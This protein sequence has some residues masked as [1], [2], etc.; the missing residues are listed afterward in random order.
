MD[1]KWA[2][3]LKMLVFLQS[4]ISQKKKTS[5][6]LKMEKPATFLTL[7]FGGGGMVGKGLEHPLAL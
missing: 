5:K 3:G 2:L 4:K 6:F 7:Q 1:C